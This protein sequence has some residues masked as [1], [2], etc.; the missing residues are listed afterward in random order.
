M[1]VGVT[2]KSNKYEID[3]CN[4]PLLGKIFMF[5]LPL[6]LSSFLQLLFNAADMVVVGRFAGSD[7]LAAVGS[8]GSL[9]N[10]IV[11]VFMG[12]SV[13]ANVMTARYFGAGKEKELSDVVHTAIALALIGGTVLI[14]IGF[15]LAGPALRLMGTPEDVIDKSVLYMRIYFAGMP[16]MMTYNFGSAILRAVGDTR[17]PMYYLFLA[18]I[19]NVLLNLFFVIVFNM[20][21]AGVALA[22]VIS[23]IVAAVLV[24]RDLVVTKSAYQLKLKEVKLSKNMLKDILSIG[25]PAG[26]QSMLFSI[27]NVLIQYSVNSFGSI[28]VAGN[29]AG[30]NLCSFVYTP[31][32][33][34][35]QAAISFTSQN[36]GARKYTRI[37]KIIQV[38]LLLV[39]VIGILLGCGVTGFSDKLLLLYSTDP[40]VIA[41]GKIRIAIMCTTYWI[42]GM[43]DVM[44]GILRGIGYAIIPTLVS[45]IGTCAFRVFWVLVVFRYF[46]TLQCLF[47]SYPISWSV[48]FIV[49]CICFFIVF[50]T[51]ILK[52]SQPDT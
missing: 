2:A 41:Y 29:S 48:T 27:S 19:I 23:Q 45:I 32:N 5:T 38:N 18:G 52:K 37:S 24:I 16:V 3:M 49:L 44:V 50:H 43:M 31:L 6:M 8:T 1:S 47:L 22:T 20:D 26:V 28:E 34:F 39:F 35:H 46:R 36:Y 51:R 14:V 4:G 11:N 17:R 33:S 15:W 7:S 30:S 9:T 10:L 13:G 42:A 40:E 21:V 25:L 12:L